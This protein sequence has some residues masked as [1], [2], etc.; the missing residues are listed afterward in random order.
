MRRHHHRPHPTPPQRTHAHCSV[1]PHHLHPSHHHCTTAPPLSG[2]Y[3]GGYIKNN[4][5]KALPSLMDDKEA[6]A[7]CGGE[8]K[9][10]GGITIQGSGAT[11]MLEGV[12]SAAGIAKYDI[13]LCG[14]YITV[15]ELTQVLVPC[16]LESKEILE[17][18]PSLYKPVFVQGNNSVIN[19]FQENILALSQ[20][21]VGAGWC[22]C[23]L[24]ACVPMPCC[25][26]MAWVG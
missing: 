2:S 11:T 26:C 18:V 19:L 16:C 6:A 21:K 9:G 10:R 12:S 3:G 4:T 5:G 8:G 17:G 25:N 15:H 23:V 7:Q 13:P 1:A 24:S 20:E 22:G 14:G